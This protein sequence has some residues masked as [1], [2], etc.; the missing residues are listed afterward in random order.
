[1]D[2]LWHLS[3]LPLPLETLNLLHHPRLIQT[4]PDLHSQT[5]SCS[6]II[7]SSSLSSY[8]IMDSHVSFPPFPFVFLNCYVFKTHSDICKYSILSYPVAH[9]Q[10]ES[11]ISLSL[12]RFSKATFGC[13][14]STSTATAGCLIL[15]PMATVSPP[16][17]ASSSSSSLAQGTLNNF[18]HLTSSDKVPAA[19]VA[20]ARW[21]GHAVKPSAKIHDTVPSISSVLAKRSAVNLSTVTTHSLVCS[22]S[23]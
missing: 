7:F 11:V 4:H 20:G 5:F 23:G 10:V 15:T 17:T 2:K 21:S 14:L 13:L 22:H 18:I 16:V 1:M 12:I 9:L 8:M 3:P 6:F 19:L